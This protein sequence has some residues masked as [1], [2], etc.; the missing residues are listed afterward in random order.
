MSW[1]VDGNE[2]D[3]PC[4]IERTSEIQSSD[5]SGMMLDK[6]YFND[7][8]GTYMQ[9]NLKVA[10]PFGY[11]DEYNDLYEVLTEPVAGHD[12]SFPY[13]DE[14][15]EF[16]GRIQDVKDVYVRLPDGK[17]HWR[18]TSFTVIANEPSKEA[19]LSDVIGA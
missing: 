3:I 8:L 12:F 13:A 1:F 7:V 11:E 16:N 10:V 19:Q 18:G 5:I 4:T 6:T 17:M 2:W 15:I 14:P 9:Y